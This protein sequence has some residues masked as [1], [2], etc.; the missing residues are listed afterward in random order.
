MSIKEFTRWRELS[1]YSLLQGYKDLMHVPAEQN[2]ILSER[3]RN[4]MAGLAKAQ[5]DLEDILI[6]SEKK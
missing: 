6:D 2:I 5:P 4:E 3:L 1:S